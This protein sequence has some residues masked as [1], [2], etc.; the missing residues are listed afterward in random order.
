M[1]GTTVRTEKELGESLKRG[2][3]EI[4]I[5]GSLK[6][7]V[8]RI[9]AT[10]KVAWLVAIG[11]ISV[12]VISIIATG[13]SGGTASPITAPVAFFTGSEAAIALGGV[14]TAVSATLIAVAA[15]GVGAL[16]KLRKYK[17]VCE[18]HDKIVLKRK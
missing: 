13:G 18:D 14:P 2:D 3:D 16:N 4:E 9:R 15:G 8:I 17:T 6:D 7:K 10:G 1:S 5:E 11:A 12:A